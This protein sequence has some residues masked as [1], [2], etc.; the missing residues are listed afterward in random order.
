[1]PFALLHGAQNRMGLAT[2]GADRRGGSGVRRVR[3]KT[4]STAAAMS[5]ARRA[6][7]RTAVVLYLIQKA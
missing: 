7:T 5:D 6:T 4:G 2:A 1:M 3:Y